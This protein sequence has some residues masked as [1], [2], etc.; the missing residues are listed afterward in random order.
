MGLQ[1]AVKSDGIAAGFIPDRNVRSGSDDIVTAQAVCMS[2]YEQLVGAAWMCQ[3]GTGICTVA[4]S[5]IADKPGACVPSL[6]Q[7]I[8]PFIPQQQSYGGFEA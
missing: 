3:C 6:T 8:A 1:A 7:I 4:V 2:V 5:Y